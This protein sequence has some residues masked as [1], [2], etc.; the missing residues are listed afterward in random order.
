[1]AILVVGSGPAGVSAAYSL[2]RK[3]LAVTMLDVG[4]R[5]EPERQ[6]IVDRLAAG[7]PES[8]DETSLD[9]LRGPTK[10]SARGLPQKLVYGSDFP[11]RAPAELIQLNQHRTDLVISH[12]LGG[13]ST[14]WGANTIP[15]LAQDITNWPIGLT[16]LAPY[17]RAVFSFV[18]LA[19]R[20]DRLSQ[21]FPLYTDR[22]QPLRPS[23]QAAALLTAL[24]QHRETLVRH[25]FEFGQSRLAVRTYPKGGDAGCVYCGLCLY[26]CPY[27]L[28]YCS[29]HTLPELQQFS[30][31]KYVPGYYVERL[32]ESAA[33]VTIHA[34]R[35]ADGVRQQF[36]AER[37][38]LG[39]GTVSTTK[40]VLESLGALGREILVSDSQYFL[41]PLLRL[42]AVPNVTEERLH[43][44][45]QVCLLLRDPALSPRSIHLL[46]YTYNDLY[47]R[48]LEKLC[49]IRSVQRALLS[50]LVIIQGYLHSDDSATLALRLEGA[51]GA[52][53]NRVVLE[54]HPNPRT[55]VMIRQVLR[56][57]RAVAPGLQSMIVPFMTNVVAPGKSYHVGASLPM[58]ARPGDFE[59][60]VLG[61]PTGLT[62]VH[63]V[64]ASCFSSVPA[65]NI[66]LTVMA[67]AY[68]IADQAVES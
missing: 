60:D 59:C 49:P 66:T 65:T 53:P 64:D 8:W 13:L 10:A 14:A 41:T 44:L 58:R 37:V 42:R 67:N 3:G 21:L 52:G 55:R 61:R 18:D 26:G 40:I 63:L 16:E 29:A 1:M 51:A 5:L 19:A 30:N 38:F 36:S 34:C 35:V 24:E 2:L 15:F 50:R 4:F 20:E 39:C 6:Q 43:T 33:G 57:L 48:A 68:R 28:I 45:S 54:G 7:T 27:A 11:Y 62:R 9:D 17:Y 12:A 47:R 31:F 46:I 56:R 32:A 22:N 25:G 23:R